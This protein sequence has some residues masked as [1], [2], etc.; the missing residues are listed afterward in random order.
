MFLF[1]LEL[2]LSSLVGSQSLT[3]DTNN[4]L[5]EVNCFVKLVLICETSL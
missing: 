2:F 3:D 4:D 1:D 5:Q